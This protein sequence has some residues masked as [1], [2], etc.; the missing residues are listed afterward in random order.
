MAPLSRS[1]P[2]FAAFVSVS[3]A[4]A[5]DLQRFSVAS[6][7]SHS[8][9]LPRQQHQG[10][11]KNCPPL[12]PL[13]IRF[14]DRLHMILPT[15]CRESGWS[16]ELSIPHPVH[17][18]FKEFRLSSLLKALF[19]LVSTF[20]LSKTWVPRGALF[21]Q[22]AIGYRKSELSSLDLDPRLPCFSSGSA[23]PKSVLD[24]ATPQPGTLELLL[25]FMSF[26]YFY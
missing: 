24:V 10:S 21:F 13:M 4:F 11:S 1:Y 8:A 22:T 14:R 20:R 18:F 6:R 12:M 19:A 5:C 7:Q 9:W 3:R 26:I 15:L 17:G 23:S 16:A 25:P 2:P